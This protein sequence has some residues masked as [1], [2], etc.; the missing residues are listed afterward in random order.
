MEENI[1]SLEDVVANGLDLQDN[2]KPEDKGYD[3]ITRAN[4]MLLKHQEEFIKIDNDKDLADKKLKL[5]EEKLAHEK[6][7]LEFEREKA[8]LE[9]EA[10]ARDAKIQEVTNKVTLVGVVTTTALGVGKIVADIWLMNK[11]GKFEEK[12]VWR[13]TA[14][15]LAMNKFGKK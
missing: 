10:K 14:S 1:V 11:V 8:K 2:M 15:R 12:G 7:K 13:S 4:D 6:E 3:Q 9:D 5:E